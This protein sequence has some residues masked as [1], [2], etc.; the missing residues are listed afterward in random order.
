MDVRVVAAAEA[1]P[2]QAPPASAPQVGA[3]Q[4][5]GS[6]TQTSA[7][8]PQAQSGVLSPIVAKLFSG[9][10]PQPVSVNVS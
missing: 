3:P 7:N 4:G 2:Q 10:I 8:A 9:G 6:T 5:G 1:A